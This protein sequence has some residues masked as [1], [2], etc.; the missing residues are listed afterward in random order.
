MYLIK[1]MINF[2]EQK[3]IYDNI[4]EYDLLLCKNKLNKLPHKKIEIFSIFL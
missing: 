1:S 3:Y 4:C 2:F